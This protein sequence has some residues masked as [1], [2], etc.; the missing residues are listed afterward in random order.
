[1]QNGFCSH[2]KEPQTSDNRNLHAKRRFPAGI[3]LVC[4]QLNK[5]RNDGS[6]EMKQ[7]YV[8]PIPGHTRGKRSVDYTRY[9][10]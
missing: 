7:A 6:A 4:Q 9:I 8:S 2:D 1:M 5:W 10:T 3:E